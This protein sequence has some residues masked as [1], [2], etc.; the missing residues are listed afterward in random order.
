MKTHQR[1]KNHAWMVHVAT[2]AFLCLLC[3]ACS[4]DGDNGKTDV[5]N[6]PYAKWDHNTAI[7]FQGTLAGDPDSTL[8]FA[9][10]PNSET[11]DANGNKNN[12]FVL[13]IVNGPSDALSPQSNDAITLEGNFNNEGPVHIKSVQSN[14]FISKVIGLPGLDIL[15]NQPIE[16]PE[17][18]VIDIDAM[19]QGEVR[20][21]ELR[22]Q[23]AGLPVPMQVSYGI[24]EDNVSVQTPRGHVIGC[25]KVDVEATIELLGFPLSGQLLQGTI[26]YHP[27]L[28]IVAMEAPSLGIGL[29]MTETPNYGD[30]ASG[31]NTL[32]KTQV[33]TANHREFR[34]STY[35]RAA[36]FDAD[37]NVHAKMLLELRWADE[38]DA[39]T[40]PQPDPFSL[41]TTFG[42]SGGMF[43]FP[44]DFIESPISVFFPEE[45]GNG[46]RYWYAYVD[47]AAK[48]QPEDA[49]TYEINS[50]K[51]ASLP[52]L[53]VTGRIGYHL[54][55]LSP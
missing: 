27:T 49:I 54:V 41:N 51:D 40:L 29:P 4:G 31:W 33:L 25:R 42:T 26:Y 17:P 5:Q 37:K 34:L 9:K 44:H 18:V 11:I 50:I 38:G 39:T 21:E 16:L 8:K 53:R 12:H 48:N 1:E 24:A 32:Q 22:I 28:A 13:G 43:Y 52:D 30:A 47:Q 15:E 45:N 2:G 20:E 46:F 7:V 55:P 35:D 6:D 19:H 36:E 14:G 23:I 10:V 3:A